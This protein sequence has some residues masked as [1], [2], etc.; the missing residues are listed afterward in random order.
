MKKILFFTVLALLSLSLVCCSSAEDEPITDPVPETPDTSAED[1]I[2]EYW[3]KE[4]NT[5]TIALVTEFWNK[6][7]KFFN[8]YAGKPD[9]AA[10]DWCY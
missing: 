3:Q 2:C 10:Q 9:T 4:A 1:E 5:S 7:K 8:T 6:D